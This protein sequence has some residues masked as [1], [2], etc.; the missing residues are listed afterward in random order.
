VKDLVRDHRHHPLV[1][2]A[3]LASMTGS[4]E[5]RR[6]HLLTH[7]ELAALNESSTPELI[8]QFQQAGQLSD[9]QAAR[10]LGVDNQYVEVFQKLLRRLPEVAQV[11]GSHQGSLEQLA[12]ALLA[13]RLLT[14]YLEI[15]VPPHLSYDKTP[16]GTVDLLETLLES[17]R[18]IVGGIWS[19]FYPRG[20]L[21]LLADASAQFWMACLYSGRPDEI[22]DGFVGLYRKPHQDRLQQLNRSYA[23]RSGIH[24]RDAVTEYLENAQEKFT[25]LHE[26]VADNVLRGLDKA[27]ARI[28]QVTEKLELP[29]LFC[30]GFARLVGDV[31]GAFA[32]LDGAVSSRENRF[33][34]YLL[35]QIETLCDEHADTQG[36]RFASQ[37]EQLDQVLKELD[38]LVGLDTVKER[39]RQVAN[40]AKV[41]QMR[42]A[43]NL[44]AISTSYHAVY[45]G[46]PGTGKTTVA[47]LMGRIFRALGVLRKGHLIE[48]DRASLVAEYVGQTAPKTSAVIESALDGI[49]FID[50]AYSLA[51]EGSEDFGHEAIETLLKRMEDHRDRLIVIVAGYPSEMDQFIHSNP[52]LESRFSRFIEFP[53]YSPQQLSRIFALLCRRNGLKTNPSL[54][55]KLLHHFLLL[56][57]E[58]DEQFG[59]ARLVRN[60]FEHTINAQATRLATAAEVD[61]AALSLLLDSDLDSPAEP[62][63]EQFRNA[64]GRYLIRCP[65]CQKAYTWTP[66]MN[67][68]DALCTQ[69]N[70]TY[71]CEFGEL[72]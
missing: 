10:L 61:P 58:R 31:C 70:H 28:I 66:D 40:F 62:S 34:R 9:D 72:V 26:A 54:R 35:R 16:Q 6:A 11:T 38:G 42:I 5:Q 8:A 48:C 63:L 27:F 22:P 45:T 53:D 19:V 52:G 1:P 69:C 13:A 51:R 56:W 49:L 18:R 14:E 23:P 2:G 68:T 67:L 41:Q 37:T 46:N 17:F 43:Q 71:N 7:E 3:L 36:S 21:S 29:P 50:E 32:H 4:P 60:C 64:K 39:V 33:A 24:V 44:P 55:E 59:N 15:L 20:E 30:H 47:R 25:R 65:N 57:R 12:R